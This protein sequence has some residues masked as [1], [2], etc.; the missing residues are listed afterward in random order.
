M[1]AKLTPCDPLRVA[2]TIACL[3]RDEAAV[4]AALA[5]GASPYDGLLMS[6]TWPQGFDL[7]LSRSGPKD[8]VRFCARAGAQGEARL[9]VEAWVRRERLRG[10]LPKATDD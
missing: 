9:R 1:D 10:M 4:I 6:I 7:V 3:A 8:R 2:F 5:D